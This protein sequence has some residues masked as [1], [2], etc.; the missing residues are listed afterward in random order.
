MLNLNNFSAKWKLSKLGYMA[1][2]PIIL[3]QKALEE[4]RQIYM[5]KFQTKLTLKQAEKK[6]NN[7]IQ[8]FALIT[9]Q[10]I[11]HG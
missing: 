7:F 4:Y 6:A 8:L 11:K 5:E 10:P 1:N 3:P 9:N 2:K